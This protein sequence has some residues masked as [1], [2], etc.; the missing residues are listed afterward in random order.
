[1][2]R[3]PNLKIQRALGEHLMKGFTGRVVLVTGAA[4]GIGRATVQALAAAGGTVVA[5][6]LCPAEM[7]EL[8]SGD[9]LVL[10]LDVTDESAV[11][12]AI[13][14]TIG[15]YGRLD[16]VVACAGIVCNG[17]AHRVDR[18]A[19]E[20]GIAVHLTGAFLTCKYALTPMMAARTGAIVLVSSIYGMTGCAG[21]TPYNVAKGGVL[22]LMRSLAADY[23]SYGI[24]VNAVSP[25]YIET[26]MT[27]SLTGETRDAFIRMH[28]LGRPGTPGEVASAI[29]FLLSDAASFITG[30]NLPVDGGFS[31]A[32]SIDWAR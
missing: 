8:P 7:I 4:S 21:N 12:R 18:A 3:E 30:V 32:K 1:M 2:R 28:L 17:P 10:S 14:R 13:E 27:A 19:W 29:V 9:H 5:T 15:R 22:Q 6:D 23:A 16:G 20:R 24:R 26:P 11:E 31:A 25:G